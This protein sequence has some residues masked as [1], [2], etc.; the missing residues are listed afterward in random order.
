MANNSYQYEDYG[1]GKCEV[2]K[3][4]IDFEYA[5]WQAF[6]TM[7]KKRY[8]VDLSIKGCL[9]HFCQCIYRRVQQ[10]HLASKYIR[11]RLTRL[12]IKSYMALPLLPLIH[13]KTE[14]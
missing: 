10:L 4:I 8:F 7:I 6:R 2:R 9:F 11:N 5:M 13:I 12:I 3:I 1:K 14:F